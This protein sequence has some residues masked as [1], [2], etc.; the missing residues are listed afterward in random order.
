MKETEIPSMRELMGKWEQKPVDALGPLDNDLEE[1]Y[2]SFPLTD[3][4]SA[5]LKITKPKGPPPQV[6]GFPLIV[7]FHGGAFSVGSG[8]MVAR[9]AR[10]FAK[11]F[12]AVVVAA[13][14]RL[15]PEYKFPTQM[16]DG[17]D[18]LYG[19]QLDRGFILG[20]FSS[21]ATVAAVLLQQARDQGLSPSLT[22][23]FISIPML[24]VDE[25][26]PEC[27]RG[28]WKSREENTQDPAVTKDSL[29][30]TMDSWIPDI[31]SP[32]FSPFNAPN[33]HKG[34]PPTYVQVGGLDPLRDDGLIYEKALRENGVLTRLDIY[35]ELTHAAW[36]IFANESS[37]KDLGT[38][39]MKAMEWLLGKT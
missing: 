16:E 7:L 20:G 12:Q 27:Y 3:G 29:Q 21:G 35:S 33:P 37:P 23:G 2:G 4:H 9:P 39:T 25:I 14:Y 24:L 6:S 10:D 26:V 19:V 28:E 8:N 38:N 1:F 11:Q 13:T 30:E 15:L 17:W 32:L 18:A 34:L 5:E 22:G 36:T 31:R